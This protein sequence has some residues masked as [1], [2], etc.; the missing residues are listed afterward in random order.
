MAFS[1]RK[2][3]KKENG[4]T[5]PSPRS[6]ARPSFARKGKKEN[7]GAAKPKPFRATP[8]AK[9]ALIIGDEGAILIY[10]VGKVVQS[11]NFIANATS[12][13]LREFETILSKDTKAPIFMIVD[14]MD[15]SFVQQSLP[16]IS[17][18]GV[19]KLI[20][21]RLDRDLGAD[22]IKGYVLLERDN[23]GRRDWNFLMVSLENSPH[24]NLW[25]EFIEK[26]DNRLKGIYLLSVEA[27]NII[28]NI[29]RVI[30]PPKK[31]KKNKEEGARWKF[32]VTHNKVGGFRQVILKDGRIIF[33]RLTQPVGEMTTDVIAGNIEQEMNS[34]VEYMKRLSFSPQQ[35]LDI[36]IVASSEINNSLDISRIPSTNVHRFTPYE[37]AGFFGIT[38]AAQPSDQ[39][40]D[41]IMAAF[42]ACS[43]VHR[44]VLFLPK[45]IKIN[46]IYNAMRY[47]RTA[48]GLMVLGMLIYSGMLGLG[49]MQKYSEVENLNQKKGIQQRKL[50]AINNEVKKSGIDVKKVSDTVALY[51]RLIGETQSPIKLLSR[52]RPAIIP[53]VAIKEIS[54][55]G[56]NDTDTPAAGAA[57]SAT[58][59]EETLAV[60]LRF[61]EISDTDEAFKAVA[62][63]VLTDVRAAFPDYKVVYTKLPDALSR[64]SDVGEITFNNKD[65]LVEIDKANLEATLT[66][67]K[68]VENQPGVVAPKPPGVPVQ[69]G[70]ANIST[71]EIIGL[72]KQ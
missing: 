45:V 16:P 68:Q 54:W 44:L 39:F 59:K 40:G 24:L 55:Q 43:R 27:E 28:K 14:S 15:Q 63:K 58:P 11:R 51:H 46:Y 13:N 5:P 71:D 19:K 61:P 18:L 48:V 64:K 32:F 9:Y 1:F 62:K 10:V 7:G 20:K 57:V 66:L 56:L 41:V 4:D 65:T 17:P 34:T 70:A 8:G 22:I 23:S 67:T 6:L 42:I 49:L 33:T 12:E 50:D 26:V 25:F 21:R 31:G 2:S 36:Y 72:G 37:V 38:G 35:G 60:V 52:I 69:G 30:H 53:S 29:D 47:Q 3:A